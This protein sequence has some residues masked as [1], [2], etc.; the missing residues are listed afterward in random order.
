MQCPG[1]PQCSWRYQHAH[2][3]H[4]RLM[5]VLES[6]VEP[7]PHAATLGCHNVALGDAGLNADCTFLRPLEFLNKTIRYL[8]REGGVESPLCHSHLRFKE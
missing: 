8:G 3:T 7:G 1:S 6:I 2:P 5:H 4:M